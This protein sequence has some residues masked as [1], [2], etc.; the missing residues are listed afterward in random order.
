MTAIERLFCHRSGLCKKIVPETEEDFDKTDEDIVFEF[1][2]NPFI[3]KTSVKP[4]EL[5]GGH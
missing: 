4:N 2:V 5:G 3:I 1:I